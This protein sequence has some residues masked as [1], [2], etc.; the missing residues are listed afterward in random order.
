MCCTAA[1]QVLFGRAVLLGQPHTLRQAGDRSV[2]VLNGFELEA[3]DYY[4]CTSRVQEGGR[5]PSMGHGQHITPST[6]HRDT[7]E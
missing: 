2:S 6:S 1:V 4:K 3:A 5:P 7:H